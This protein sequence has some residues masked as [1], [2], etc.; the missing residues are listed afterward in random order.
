MVRS[1]VRRLLG[2]VLAL[3]CVTGTWTGAAPPETKT[4]APAPTQSRVATAKHDAACATL[5]STSAIAALDRQEGLELQQRL[6]DVYRGDPQLRTTAAND[7]KPLTDGVI[8]PI[9][10][11]WLQR[12]CVDFAIPDLAADS[13]GL[14]DAVH[15][16]AATLEAHDRHRDILVGADLGRWIAS[17]P[18]AKRT[19][20]VTTRVFGGSDEIVQLM[21]AFAA[22]APGAPPREIDEAAVYYELTAANLAKL[23]APHRALDAIAKLAEKPPLDAEAFDATILGLLQAAGLP[24]ADLLPAVRRHA[25]LRTTHQ[26]TAEVI[27][28]LKV[29][30]LP[31]AAI[32]LA[33]TVQDLPFPDRAALAG[34]LDDAIKAAAAAPPPPEAPPESPLEVRK[35]TP[36]AAPPSPVAEK[37]AASAEP[38]P[39]A[40]PPLAAP[41][42]APAPPAPRPTP[43]PAPAPAPNLAPFAKEIVKASVV[44][45]SFQVTDATVEALSADPDFGAL[46]V[47]LLETLTR[48]QDVEYPTDALFRAAVKARVVDEFLDTSPTSR[49][50]KTLKSMKDIQK[51]SPP[52]AY[53]EVAREIAG[54]ITLQRYKSN[55]EVRDELAERTAMLVAPHLAAVEIVARQRHP[56]LQDEVSVWN[57]DGCGCVLDDRLPGG[58]STLGGRTNSGIVYGLFPVWQTGREQLIDFSVLS[59]VG[60]YAVPFDD[61]G[62]LQDPLSKLARN[63][64]RLDFVDTAHRHGARVD[65]IVRRVDWSSWEALA[66]DARVRAFDNLIDNIEKML[67]ESSGHWLRQLASTLSMGTIPTPHRGDGVTLYFD[68]YPE[69]LPSIEAFK[70]FHQ[71]LHERLRVSVGE[72]YSVNLLFPASSLGTGIHQC[73]SLVELLYGPS[74]TKPTN[75]G[76]FLVFLSEPSIDRKKDLRKII[77]DCASGKRRKD[78]QQNVVPIIQYNGYDEHQLQD[79]VVYFDF[80]FGGIGL[81]PHP[82]ASDMPAAGPSKAH[83]TAE[84]I[85]GDIRQILTGD[86]TQGGEVQKGLDR[87]CTFVCPNRWV[88][89]G[90]F[91]IFLAILA[92]SFIAR[93][94]NCRLNF[95]L[96]AR[97][98]YFYLYM[99]GVVAPT[100]VLFLALL[101][102]DPAWENIREGNIPF[103][104]LAVTFIGFV[105]WLY[106]DARRQAS[107]P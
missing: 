96:Q 82:V 64:K 102:C 12:F 54:N 19:R 36:A 18:A 92:V 93:L 63:D 79:D 16:F 107:R 33:Q 80:N 23:A 103:L 65:W 61:T 30:R 39:T 100:L 13:P 51:M 41:V 72:K 104:L 4:A 68:G 98:A 21:A 27:R 40:A 2:G 24:A 7:P 17:L 34:A 26:V 46:P 66:M 89:R 74:G 91:E 38:P 1:M 86:R 57:G 55:R 5:T 88:F 84:Q 22:Q 76:K 45:R 73:D 90:L 14:V 43:A 69:D 15:A 47:F 94:T 49:S 11:T 37:T 75:T 9:T 83:V 101:Y 29:R 42:T 56:F 78:I 10:R 106:V 60:Y 97:P 67:R 95:A 105:I 52:A 25:E 87:V 3:A 62:T 53:L 32:A 48:L 77:E 58:G 71:K 99:G 59:S 6:R 50:D 20:A 81:W 70:N 8:G 85:G 35:P 44:G 31:P 28:S